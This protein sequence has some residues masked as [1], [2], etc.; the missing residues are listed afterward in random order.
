MEKSS[1]KRFTWGEIAVLKEYSRRLKKS[2]ISSSFN[3][4][5]V[6]GYGKATT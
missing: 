6:V 3:I 4:F 1:K 2:S 5:N